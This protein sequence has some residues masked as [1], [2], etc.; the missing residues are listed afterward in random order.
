MNCIS[1]P[2]CQTAWKPSFL[3]P[4]LCGEIPLADHQPNVMDSVEVRPRDED[5]RSI[6][7]ILRR[8]NW[9]LYTARTVA[10]ALRLLQST[11][12]AVILC[13]PKLPDGSWRDLLEALSGSEHPPRL[14]LTSDIVDERLWAEALNLGSF[15]LLL[16]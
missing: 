15:D 4:S 2:S 6:E 16:K 3:Q 9:T 11:P 10:E 8:S 14:I 5:H 13:E 7:A 12:A 1:R